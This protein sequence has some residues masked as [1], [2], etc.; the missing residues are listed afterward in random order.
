M[1]SL[2]LTAQAP[3]RQD[4]LAIEEVTIRRKKTA[5]RTTEGNININVTGT[6]HFTGGS[7]SEILVRNTG[8]F[9]K[10]YG[11]GGIASATLRGTPASHTQLNWNGVN[12][13]NPML[14]Q[15]D[16]SLVPAGFA[17]DLKVYC[18]GSSLRLNSGGIGGIITLETKPDWQKGD[19]A[20]FSIEKG[21]FGKIAGQVKIKAGN[22][23]RQSVTRAFYN[24]A[25]NDFTY[26]NE[27]AGIEPARERRT[28]NAIAQKGLM[29]ELFVRGPD[30]VLSARIWYHSALRELP[31]PIII[32]KTR[33][34]EKQ[35][36]RSLKTLVN[37]ERKTGSASIAGGLAAI[38][39]VL[40]YSNTTTGID[41]RNRTASYTASARIETDAGDNLSLLFSAG[42]EINIVNSNNFGERKLRNVLTVMASARIYPARRLSCELLVRE[43]MLNNRLLLPDL[44]AGFIFDLGNVNENQ[45]QAGVSRNSRYPSLNDLY[46]IPGGNPDLGN[47]VAHAAELTWTTGS[48]LSDQ[49]ALKTGIT[50]FGNAVRN[51]IKWKPGEFA[52]WT[53]VNI[54]QVNTSGLESVL[55]LAWS[56]TLLEAGVKT[57]YTYV[58]AL[59]TENHEGTVNPGKNRLT[60]VPANQINSRLYASYKSFYSHFLANFTGKRFLT[61]DNASYLPWYVYNDLMLGRKFRAGGTLFDLSIT[62]GNIFN[63]AYQV[64]AYY[65]MPG[66]SFNFRFTLN[67]IKQTTR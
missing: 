50:L 62:A 16:L 8:I 9:I 36:D 27:S 29:Q 64:V 14:G 53:P 58:L 60:Y 47:E 13:G 54:G 52:Y 10:S 15:A 46:W 18:G 35:Y 45:L 12:I 24:S 44:Y 5:V 41:S 1:V 43:T 7:V 39:D 57:S 40:N 4:T 55:D 61:P 11:P 59:N 28:F 3:L 37:Y 38:Y 49:L 48:K 56:G 6:D 20:S 66:R 2:P 33:N 23:K 32:H 65:P 17:D 30:G 26:I 51:M 34:D 22:S 21:S 19:N 63:T 25:E 31:A 42:N 67:L